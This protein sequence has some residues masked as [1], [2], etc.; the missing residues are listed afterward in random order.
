VYGISQIPARTGVHSGD[1]HNAGGIGDAGKR[2]GYGDPTVFHRLT[3]DFQDVLLKLVLG[4][5]NVNLI[6]SNIVPQGS[7]QI[8]PLRP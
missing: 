8:G 7:N 2:A 4:I 6:S 1:Q 5:F 3:Q